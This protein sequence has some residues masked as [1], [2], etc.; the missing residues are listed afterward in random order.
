MQRRLSSWV[1]WALGFAV[2]LGGA[3]AEEVSVPVAL[4]VDLLAKVVAYDRNL[5][6]RAGGRVVSLIVVK[7]SDGESVRAGAQAR[8]AFQQKD[9]LAGLPHAEEVVGFTTAARLAVACKARQA[10]IVYVAPGFS[11][12]EVLGIVAALDGAGVMTATAVARFVSKGLTLGFDLV[13]GKPKL[14]FSLPQATRQGVALSANVLS[15]MT[16]YR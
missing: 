16:V 3:R 12:D 8:T 1:G 13:A 2:A 7:E 6:E 5:P 9:T 11:D 14:L 10:S 15:L 4:Q